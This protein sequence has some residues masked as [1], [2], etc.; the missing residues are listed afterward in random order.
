[1]DRFDS[2]LHLSSKSIPVMSAIVVTGS[3]RGLGL[4]LVKQL[5]G[6]V[7]ET[8]G[9]LIV[10]ARRCTPALSEAIAQSKGSAVSVPLDVTDEEQVARSVEEVR[11][12]LN[13]HS[14]NILLNCAGVHGEIHGKI[15]LMYVLSFVTASANSQV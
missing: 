5:F 10:T 8:S 12:T 4:E 9:L 11:S 7:S 2:H 6:R 13:G 15:A 14:L 3:S 1:M